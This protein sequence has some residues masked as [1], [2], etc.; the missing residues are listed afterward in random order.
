MYKIQVN[1]KLKT[2]KYK[3]RPSSRIV[4]RPT[5]DSIYD[6]APSP[7]WEL[8]PSRLRP[9]RKPETSC[10]GVSTNAHFESIDSALSLVFTKVS[11]YTYV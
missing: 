4:Q 10:R 7:P 6:R 5:P 9:S 8:P 3:T 1:G 2:A 11:K